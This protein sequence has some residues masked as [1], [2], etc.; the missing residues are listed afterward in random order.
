MEDEA[1][2]LV[3]LKLATSPHDVA[4][5]FGL[6][7]KQLASLIYPKRGSPYRFFHVRKKSGGVRL[8]AAPKRRLKEVQRK[9]SALLVLGYEPRPSVHG[10][11]RDKS[12]VTNADRHVGKSFVFNVDIED[13]FGSIHF[14]RV[15]NLLMAEPYSLPLRVATVLAHICCC[16]RKLPQGAPTSPIVT[17]LIC[18]RLDRDLQKLAKQSRASYSRYVDDITFSFTCRKS[19]LPSQVVVANE[20]RV[21]AGDTLQRIIEANGFHL[22]SNKTRLFGRAQ[23]LEVT[24]LVVNDFVNVRRRFVRRLSSMIYACEKHGIAAAEREFNAKYA[25][26]LALRATDSTRALV[27]ILKGRLAFLHMVRGTRDPI[28]NKLARRFNDLVEGSKQLPVHH[29]S[30]TEAQLLESV[31]VIEVLYDDPNSPDGGPKASSG[32]GFFLEG[33]GFITAAHVVADNDGAYKSI[34]AF[35][36]ADPTEVYKVEVIKYDSHRDLAVCKVLT[37]SGEEHGPAHKFK[38]SNSNVAHKDHVSL[39]GYPSYKLGQKTPFVAETKVGSIYPLHGVQMFE[40]VAQIREG[41]SGGPV[42]NVNCEVIGVAITGAE[43]SGGSN[44]VVHVAELA[45][46]IPPGD[47][48]AAQL[49]PGAA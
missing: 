7:Y 34:S 25:S 11:I 8:I 43:K 17:N 18:R 45:Q 48:Q 3:Q 33:F 9:L 42:V 16:D 46:L 32:T 38:A 49:Y 4:A 26:Q 27:D 14:G 5:L 28:Y 13:F 1:N 39:I 10:F 12:I 24:G 47:G 6:S 41:N 30:A 40:I 19:K 35:S 15:R 37:N 22:N 44:G 36:S 20:D 21:G 2:G 29:Q 31:F 23:R